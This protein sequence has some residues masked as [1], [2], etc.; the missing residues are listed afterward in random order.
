MHWSYATRVSRTSGDNRFWR[1]TELPRDGSSGAAHP[2][3]TPR[4]SLFHY[5][6][7]QSLETSA[8]PKSIDHIHDVLSAILRPAVKWGHVAANPARGV[9]MPRLKTVRPKWALT[10]D[11]AIALFEHLPWLKPRTIVGVALLGGARRGELFAFRWRD[12]DDANRCLQVREAVYEGVFDEP[13][14]D[15]GAR[16][17]NQAIFGLRFV[18]RPAA[19]CCSLLPGK[20]KKR[21]ISQERFPRRRSSIGEGQGRTMLSR[22]RE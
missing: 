10:V 17:Q 9:E 3:M 19:V 14:T 11:Q 4:L 2:R 1:T 13:K 6:H 18:S 12:F 15:A 20:G 21:A 8:I 5:P 16:S 22:R 7:D